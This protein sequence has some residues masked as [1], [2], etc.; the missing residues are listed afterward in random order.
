MGSLHT[1]TMYGSGRAYCSRGLEGPTVDRANN[2]R[3]YDSPAFAAGGRGIEI[4]LY[5]L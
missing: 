4:G 2:A 5:V 3:R 1:G